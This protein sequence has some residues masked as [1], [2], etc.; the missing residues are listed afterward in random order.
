MKSNRAKDNNHINRAL[1]ELSL[2]P[3]ELS[4]ALHLSPSVVSSWLKEGNL[5]PSWS[6]VAI[7]GLY[8]RRRHST[9]RLLIASVP[10]D[11]EELIGE[12]LKA[13]GCESISF[14]DT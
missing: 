8:R 11:K 9:P 14:L 12:F 4:A 3:R 10:K 7:E 1:K 6:L 5:A 2:T 13:V